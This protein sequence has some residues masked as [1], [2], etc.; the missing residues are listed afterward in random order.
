MKLQFNLNWEVRDVNDI[1]KSVCLR[2]CVC[3]F[4][5]VCVTYEPELYIE[6]VTFAF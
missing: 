6:T 1:G 3:V 4:V 5:C 2:R